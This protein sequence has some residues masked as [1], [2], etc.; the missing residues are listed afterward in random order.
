[1]PFKL[2]LFKN[3]T[4]LRRFNSRN[5]TIHEKLASLVTLFSIP[6]ST[7]PNT[8]VS[9]KYDQRDTSSVFL[10]LLLIRSTQFRRNWRQAQKFDL[11]RE[12]TPKRMS[13]LRRGANT[14]KTQI[15]FISPEAN[16]TELRRW[17]RFLLK[18][19]AKYH[20]VSPYDMPSIFFGNI[21]FLRDKSIVIGNEPAFMTVG[22][23]KLFSRSRISGL[24]LC[25][26]QFIFKNTNVYSNYYHLDTLRVVLIENYYL[27]ICSFF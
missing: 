18:A 25:L 4:F 24:M 27:E 5:E 8:F 16:G 26:E 15:N 17:L 19:A 9:E 3:A 23:Y 7:C 2:N 13:K 1:M 12:I 21:L 11:R 22:G 20:A 6:F 10:D 14:S